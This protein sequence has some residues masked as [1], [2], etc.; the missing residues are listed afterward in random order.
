MTSSSYSCSNWGSQKSSDLS[1][2]KELEMAESEVETKSNVSQYKT[3]DSL[4]PCTSTSHSLQ[5]IIRF[6]SLYQ[7]SRLNL[8]KI[9]RKLHLALL[10]VNFQSLIYLT[11]WQHSILTQTNKQKNKKPKT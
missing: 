7:Y 10:M 8:T 3:L 1:K 5:C 9:T 4:S 2:L 6:S 11:S